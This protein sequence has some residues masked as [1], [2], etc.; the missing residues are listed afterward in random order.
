MLGHGLFS[1][2]NAC[3]FFSRFYCKSGLKSK[4]DK[5]CNNI[6]HKKGK[7]KSTVATHLRSKGFISSWKSYPSILF[8][9]KCIYKGL[10]A[11]INRSLTDVLMGEDQ[12][13][14]RVY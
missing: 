11:K 13:A 3:V 4:N 8:G 14:W 12:T 7:T 5:F 9:N 1:V 6:Y 10:V 2:R